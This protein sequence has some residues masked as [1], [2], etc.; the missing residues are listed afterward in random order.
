[1]QLYF[2][3]PTWLN[4]VQTTLEFSE[5]NLNHSQF[6]IIFKI[7]GNPAFNIDKLHVAGY[8]DEVQ[9]FLGQWKENNS[10]YGW[11]GHQ[12]V[13]ENLTNKGIEK[14]KQAGVELGKAQPQ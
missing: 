7:C 8:K 14:R 6:P 13:A 4:P 5:E 1:M 2:L 9:F 10:V 11:F 3:L 12:S